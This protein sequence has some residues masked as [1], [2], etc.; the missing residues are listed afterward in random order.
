MDWRQKPLVSVIIPA[1][2]A[3]STLKRCVDSVKNSGYDAV[4]IIIVDD[5]S[6]DGTPRVAAELSKDSRVTYIYQDNKGVSAARNR[7]MALC[8]G[9]YVAFVDA[10]DY[11]L[12]G[13]YESSLDILEAT[14]CSVVMFE[15]IDE[16]ALG[17]HP[18]ITLDAFGETAKSEDILRGYLTIGEENLFGSAW[19]VLL[20]RDKLLKN[21]HIVF[22]QNMN[23][24][25]DLAF[26][27]EVISMCDTVAILHK[28][29][30]CYTHGDSNSAS[31]GYIERFDENIAALVDHIRRT[32]WF[33]KAHFVG[34][35]TYAVVA[36][37]KN[38]CEAGSPYATLSSKVAYTRMLRAQNMDILSMASQLPPNFP[39]QY[40]LA[41]QLLLISPVAFT[42]FFNMKAGVKSGKWSRWY[43]RKRRTIRK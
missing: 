27:Y 17:Q 42:I 41:A 35:R 19:R 2:N 15:Y 13:V 24:C 18:N 31:K 6:T 43:T 4:E 5:G 16:D 14:Q 20:D 22:D 8:H 21:R 37:A 36:I 10:D 33:D 25:E 26:M 1:Y 32:A 12:P 11:V 30:Y 9:A 38:C 3:E 29:F 28:P 39:R 40:K 34:Y 23:M 7:G